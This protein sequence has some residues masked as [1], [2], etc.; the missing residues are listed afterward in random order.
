LEVFFHFSRA[1]CPE[2]GHKFA[3]LLENGLFAVESLQDGYN[4]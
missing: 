1:V 3:A 4:F 2:M